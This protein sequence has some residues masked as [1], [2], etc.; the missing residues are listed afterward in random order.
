MRMFRY[1]NNL[2]DDIDIEYVEGM[3]HINFTYEDYVIIST[4]FAVILLFNT[5]LWVSFIVSFLYH[6]MMTNS[7]KYSLIISIFLVLIIS[8]G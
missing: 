3:E 2:L 1:M 6:L 5:N 7:F 4:F 8:Y